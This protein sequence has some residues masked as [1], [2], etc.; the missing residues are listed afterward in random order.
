MPRLLPLLLLASCAA[1]AAAPTDAARVRTL[2]GRADRAKLEIQLLTAEKDPDREIDRRVAD[3]QSWIGEAATLRPFDDAA[4]NRQVAELGPG[5]AKALAALRGARWG[6]A[7][8]EENWIRL[9]A[10][11]AVCHSRWR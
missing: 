2:M 10:A 3:L 7:D 1:P 8:R 6:E 5:A 9:E 4:K 11:C